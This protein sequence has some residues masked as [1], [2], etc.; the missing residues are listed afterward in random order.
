MKVTEYIIDIYEPDS[1]GTVWFSF[2]SETP[3]LPINVG[4]NISPAFTYNKMQQEPEL[5]N[6]GGGLCVDKVEHSIVSKDG[7]T[8]SH[9]L[10]VFTKECDNPWN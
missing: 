5:K 7:N 2:T 3:F 8:I 1:K 10:M 9:K 4:D 6:S